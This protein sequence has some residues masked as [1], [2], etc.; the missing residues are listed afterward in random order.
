MVLKK[1]FQ[2]KNWNLK[3]PKKIK[4]LQI[5]TQHLHEWSSTMIKPKQTYEKES[6]ERVT[7]DLVLIFLR[8]IESY[9]GG[10]FCGDIVH[11]HHKFGNF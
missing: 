7:F 9:L 5:L 11:T 6:K 1:I 4:L 2:R 10:N 8:H 3:L